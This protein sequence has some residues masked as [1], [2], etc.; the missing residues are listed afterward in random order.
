MTRHHPLSQILMSWR[1]YALSFI[2]A[3]ALSACAT[4]APSPQQ[5]APGPVVEQPQPE[6]PEVKPPKKDD[7]QPPE[8]TP[9]VVERP[10]A[11]VPRTGLT[12]P[13]MR[14][15]NIKRLALL[16]PFSA[17]S[18]RLREEAGSML[19]SAELAVFERDEADVLLMAMDTGGTESGAASA[20]RAA[21]KSGADVILGPI[22]ASSVK[23]AGREARRSET[24]VIAFSTD[25]SVAGNGVYLLSFPPEAEVNRIVN[26]V[27]STGATR[28]AFLG[29]ESAYGK[30]V[31]AAYARDVRNM[32]GDLTANETYDGNDISVMQAPA[33]KLAQFYQ[34]HEERTQGQDRMA[35]EAIM[36]PE[37]GTPLRSLAPLLPYYDIDPADVQFLGTGLWHRADTVREPALNRG[38]FAGPDQDARRVFTQNYDRQF[39]EDPSRL[40]SLAFDAVNVGAFVADG[41]PAGR[42][43]RAQ[44]PNGFYGVDGLVRFTRLGTPERG[45]AVYQIQNGK[46]VII[47][48]APRTVTGPS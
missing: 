47:D 13:H 35:Y 40:A 48:P 9:E 27:A 8:E 21:L 32:G 14:G 38:I 3:V 24:P 7:T 43:A 29:P 16:L 26:F 45:L 31:Q 36:L 18:A 41:K 4:T 30:R 37:G 20:T 19:K 28:F 33:R 12:P 44:S 11:V 1:V 23:A 34:D 46:F 17:K 42:H 5:P 22:L 39:G 2:G 6:T 10:E 25:Q 15:R